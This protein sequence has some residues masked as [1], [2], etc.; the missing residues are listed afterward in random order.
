[1]SRRGEAEAS[2]AQQAAQPQDPLSHT[3]NY[4]H[5][6]LTL[7][8]FLTRQKKYAKDCQDWGLQNRFIQH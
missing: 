7:H 6:K 5:E 1:V 2:A 8:N 3:F 4:T